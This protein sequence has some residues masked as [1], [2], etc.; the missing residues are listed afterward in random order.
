MTLC[1]WDTVGSPL[2]AAASSVGLEEIQIMPLEWG[3]SAVTIRF[4][5]GPSSVKLDGVTPGSAVLFGPWLDLNPEV[6]AGPLDDNMEYI[7]GERLALLGS[8]QHLMRRECRVLNPIWRWTGSTAVQD[9]GEQ[10]RLLAEA[11]FTLAP[12]VISNV[13]DELLAW[14][15]K[16]RRK[17]AQATPGQLSGVDGLLPEADDITRGVPFMPRRYLARRP[18]HELRVLT[19]VCGHCFELSLVEKDGEGAE[20]VELERGSAVSRKAA[21]L[22]K[23]LQTDICEVLLEGSGRNMRALALSRTLGLLTPPTRLPYIL[24]QLVNIL[25]EEAK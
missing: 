20:V 23:L 19:V 14:E 25:S 11:G 1:V 16:I 4:G 7:L 13:A 8:A 10:R 12:E 15:K 5:G 21:K 18:Q 22:T 17:K 3:R 6:L 2:F 24:Q 9:T